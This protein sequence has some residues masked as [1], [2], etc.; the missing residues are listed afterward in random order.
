MKLVEVQVQNFQSVR[1]SEAF[2]IGDVTCLVGKNEAG[3]TALL[4]ALYRLNPINPADAEYSVMDDY[5]R[6][7]VST[8]EAEVTTGRRQHVQVVRATFLL[9]DEDVAGVEYTFGKSWLVDDSPTLVL[10]KGFDNKLVVE[11]LAIDTEKAI[12]HLV[13][14]ADLPST[15]AEALSKSKNLDEMLT[16]FEEGT[17]RDPETALRAA[18]QGIQEQ[19]L[20][21]YVY[22]RFLEERLPKFLYFDEY[23]QM[24]GQDN[25][26]AI[27]GRRDEGSLLD[28]D[29]PLLGLI[30]LARLDL[31]QML[32]PGNTQ[33]LVARLEGAGNNLTRQ[34]MDHWSQNRH[35]RMK[36]DVR[37][38]QPN[39]PPGM[40]SGTNIWGRVEDIRHMVTTSVGSRSRGFVWFFSFLAW[41]SQLRSKGENLI[42]LLDEPGLSL[43]AKA[44]EDLLRYFDEELVPHH[45][46]VYTTHS[47][48]MVD[49]SRF[50]RVRIV[51]D[52]SIEDGSERL[53]TEQEGTKVLTEV[54]NATPDSLF[55]LQGALGYEI[56]QTLFIGP[57]SLVVEGVSDLLYIQTVSGALH[58]AGRE[59]LSPEWTITPVGG[60]GKIPTFVTLIG[61]QSGMNTA[62]L[63][64]FQEKDRQIIENLYKEKLLKKNQVFTFA[65]FTEADEADIEDLF[66]FDFYLNLVNAEFRTNIRDDDLPKIGQRIISRLEKHFENTPL[67]NS[68]KFNHYRPARYFSENTRTLQVSNRTLDRFE[69]IFQALNRLL[70]M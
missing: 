40:I 64:D 37:A 54:L 33:T 12:E 32:D 68:S 46:V 15:L 23:Y 51:Q 31:N 59:G 17:S 22:D 50:D 20:A 67:P 11:S 45:Q 29:Y 41:Y 53:S 8:Y 3:K 28:S 14:S 52:L 61:A 39:D 42:L 26:E 18:L 6:R 19:G 58:A 10:S 25:L 48:F 55:P 70:P 30:E 36:F 27:R 69:M 63:I 57:N 24:T 9:D 13:G 7:D 47:P 38:A 43:H 49:P 44:Q 16:H 62:V 4:K 2:N 1:D 21:R 35:L 34:V 5:P 66:E 60:S 65:D 56:H